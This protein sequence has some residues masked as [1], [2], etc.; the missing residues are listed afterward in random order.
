MIQTAGATRQ[1]AAL[2][3]TLAL[4]AAVVAGCGSS[5]S[6]P[7]RRVT[8][9]TPADYGRTLRALCK[10]LNN[11]KAMN[12]EM[13]SITNSSA[14]A[15]TKLSEIFKVTAPAYKQM[16]AIVP[17]HGDAT[18]AQLR[19]DFGAGVDL[20]HQIQQDLQNSDDISLQAD[21]DAAA[22]LSTKIDAEFRLVGASICTAD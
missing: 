7:V 19:A 18:A 20:A 13:D 9:E 21:E 12:A 3:A 6:S 22:S 1:L 8:P 16:M 4:V 15:A 5:T 14:P 2:L 17:P 11:D 10:R